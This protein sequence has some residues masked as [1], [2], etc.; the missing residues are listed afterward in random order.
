MIWKHGIIIGSWIGSCGYFSVMVFACLSRDF[1]AMTELFGWTI[2]QLGLHGFCILF[3]VLWIEINKR[4]IA[5]EY[6]GNSVF[7]CNVGAWTFIRSVF[8][9]T[10]VCCS[11]VLKVCWVFIVEDG[12]MT[13]VMIICNLLV[14]AAYMMTVTEANQV[15]TGKTGIT[16]G[17]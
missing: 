8:S 11:N 12:C 4:V 7:M 15:L 1:D 5:C 3:D 17:S 2:H 10:C 9:S 6:L 16:I 14:I 13:V